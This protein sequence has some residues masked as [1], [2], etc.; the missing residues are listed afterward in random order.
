MDKEHK[1]KMHTIKV[2]ITE[3]V[4]VL[5]A[6]VTVI[7][8]TFLAMGYNVNRNGELGQSGLL[9]L[10]SIPT[11]AM[12]EIDGEIMFSKTNMSRM[13]SEGKHKLVV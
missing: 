5:V 3:I 7:V 10:K 9:Q 13:L 12:V 11:G 8:L 4:M 2:I 6:I 1:K